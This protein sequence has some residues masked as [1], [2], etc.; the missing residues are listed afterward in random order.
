MKLFDTIRAKFYQTAGG[1]VYNWF[2]PDDG[3]SKRDLLLRYEGYVYACVR[4]IALSVSNVELYVNKVT[5]KGKVNVGDHSFIQVFNRPNPDWTKNQFLQVTWTQKKIAGEAFWYMVLG[6]KTNKPKEFH[7]MRPDMVDVAV[8]QDDRGLPMVKGYV[9]TNANGT[10]VP[11]EKDE[12]IHFKEPNPMNPYRGLSAVEAGLIYVSTEKFSAQFSRN[13]IANNAMPSGIINL[14][15][16]ISEAELEKIKRQWASQ[17]QGTNNAGKTAFLRNGEAEFVKV[18]TSLSEI[19]LRGL[20]EM[21]RDDIMSMFGVSKP[22]L[23]ILDDVNLASAKA[24]H[25]IF[26]KQVT[27]PEVDTLVDTLN[28]LIRERWGTDQELGYKNVV[29]EDEEQ[30]MKELELGWGRWISTNEARRRMGLDSIINGDTLYMPINMI[31]VADASQMVK[32]QI[33]SI[34][35]TMTIKTVTTQKKKIKKEFSYEAK[36]NYRQTLEKNDNRYTKVY[37]A[38]FKKYLKRQEAE[39]INN[40]PGTTKA[41]DGLFDIDFESDELFR[42]S[43]PIMIDLMVTQGKLAL[44]FAGAKELD[45]A[46]KEAT[47]NK[48]NSSIQRMAR[49]YNQETADKIKSLMASSIA[50]NDTLADLKRKISTEIYKEASGYRAERVARTEIL[51]ASNNATIEAYKQIGYITQKEWF[52]NP[53]ACAICEE[54]NGTIVGIDK[55]FADKGTEIE[56]SDEEGNT[57]SYLVDYEDVDGPPLHPNCTCKV[58]SVAQ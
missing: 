15:G 39:V 43:Q 4:P 36:E 37:T 38:A 1:S 45:F 26:A 58:I 50:N 54:M 25:Y 6:E 10:K 33:K 48:V 13:Y 56:Y 3:S 35:A 23:G 49:N 19:D 14:K 44:D 55:A 27:K 5:A 20:K 32:N 2:T 12:V 11:L 29:P 41:I 21:T 52:T 57:T 8:G 34:P 18:G 7:L 22:I 42:V 16:T 17:Y 28:P 53:G 30:K 40:L 9:Y 46:L 47:L 51:K 24:S 31:E